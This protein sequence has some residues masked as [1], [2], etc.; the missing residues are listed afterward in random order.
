VPFLRR[1]EKPLHEQLAEGTGLL[2]WRS[3]HAPAYPQSFAGTL[4]VLHGGRPRRW[5]AVGTA[6]APGLPGD[7]LDFTALPDGTILVEDELG[8]EALSPLVEVVEQAVAPPYRAR[9]VRSDGDLWAV[10]ANAI[11]FVELTVEIPGDTVSLAVQDGE[12]TLL[13]DERPA[14]ESIPAFEQHGAAVHADFVLSAER[15]DGNLWAVEVNPL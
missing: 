14:W 5:D 2:E 9:A 11:E 4:D 1:R 13:V 12:R 10:A 3:K 8:D 15:L 6:E 7:T